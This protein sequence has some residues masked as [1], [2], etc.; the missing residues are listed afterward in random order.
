MIAAACLATLEEIL[1]SGVLETIE[2]KAY[3]YLDNFWFILKIKSIN[4][5]GIMLAVNL[6]DPGYCIKVVQECMNRGL[7][8]SCQLY[9]NEYLRISPSLTINEEEIRKGCEIILDVL[10]SDL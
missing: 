3:F 9:R 5:K 1:E 6:S 7:I 2:T 8:V 10:N 4:G